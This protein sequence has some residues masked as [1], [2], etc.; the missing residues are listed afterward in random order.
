MSHKIAVIGDKDSVLAFK[1]IGFEVFFAADANEARGHLDDLAREDYGIIFLTEQLGIQ[2][3]DAL[4][5]YNQRIT[6]AIILIPNRTGTNHFGEE[7]F[8]ENVERA[9]GIKIV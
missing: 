9:V 4:E 7:R 5:R 1:M 2:I 6:P 8:A 3:P